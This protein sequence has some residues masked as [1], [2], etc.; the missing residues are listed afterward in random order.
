MWSRLAGSISMGPV[1][2][3]ESGNL[4]KMTDIPREEDCPVGQGDARNPQVESPYA[5]SLP[6]QIKELDMRPLIIRHDVH[7]AEITKNSKE[8]RIRHKKPNLRTRPVNDRHP[9][10]NTLL[11]RDYGDGDFGGRT[12]A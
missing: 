4:A 6:G 8:L 7:L 5:D 2:Y 9:S 10:L 12:C 3:Q 11:E 1:F